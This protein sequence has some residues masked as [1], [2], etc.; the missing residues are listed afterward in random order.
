[1]EIELVFHEKHT[2]HRT[3]NFD[4]IVDDHIVLAAEESFRI[5]YW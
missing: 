1:M 5:N 3:R 2:I 4:D